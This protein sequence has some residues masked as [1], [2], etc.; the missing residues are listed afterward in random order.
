MYNDV[1][2]KELMK[3]GFKLSFGEE[4]G[5]SISHGVMAVLILISLP[6]VM[7]YVDATKNMETA[8][9]VGYYMICMFLMF[10]VSC[11]YHCMHYGTMQKYVFRKLD[12]I[13]ILFAIAGTYTP[14]CLSLLEKPMGY[15]VLAIEWICVF[16]GVLVKAISKQTHKVF[17]MILYM[18]MGWLAVFILPTLL[19]TPQFLALIVTGGL[20]YTVG[21]FF[22][23]HPQRPYN[24]FIWHLCINAASICHFIAIVFFM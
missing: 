2:S 23:S 1:M 14:I 3:N 15:I 19:K 12:H 9:G 5:N 20:F 17:S 10:I 4:V 13:M 6:I 22:Y 18:A 7:A 21:V 24:H 8:V 11:L 16:V